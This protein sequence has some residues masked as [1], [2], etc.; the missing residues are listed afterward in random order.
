M[1][2]MVIL[3]RAGGPQ[4]TGDDLEDRSEPEDEQPIIVNLKEVIWQ[5]IVNVLT[6]NFKCIDT[7]VNILTHNCNQ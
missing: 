7:T 5:V 2:T 3:Q 4:D 1:V 6:H